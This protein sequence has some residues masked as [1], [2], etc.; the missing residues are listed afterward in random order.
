[1]KNFLIICTVTFG[2][3]ACEKDTG[4]GGTSVIE[5]KVYVVDVWDNNGVWDT[6]TPLKLDAEKEVYIIYSG[7]ENDVYDDSFDTHWNGEFRFEYLRKGDYTIFTY[8][9]FDTSG[10]YPGDYPVFKHITIDENNKTFT[11]DDFILH[12]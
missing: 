5:G 10:N 7:D 6:V 9:D 1:M 12:K 11:L 2:F 8:A 4:E 3:M